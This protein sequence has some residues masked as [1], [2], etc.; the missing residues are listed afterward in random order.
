[1]KRIIYNYYHY[2][3]VTIDTFI[4]TCTSMCCYN[5]QT[6]SDVDID[7]HSSAYLSINTVTNSLVR[8]R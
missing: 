6:A 3:Y 5:H 7:I 1:M 8:G 2:G 4:C